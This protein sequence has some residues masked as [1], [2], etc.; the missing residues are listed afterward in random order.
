MS[1]FYLSKKQAKLGVVFCYTY[2][3]KNKIDNYREKFGDDC[4]EYIG[5]YL[6]HNILYDDN[7]N[8][9]VENHTPV[10]EQGRIDT[11]KY[12]I[13]DGVVKPYP[14]KDSFF[15]KPK[16][17]IENEIWIE[18][19]KDYEILEY[20]KQQIIHYTNELLKYQNAGFDN[21]TYRQCLDEY[22]KKHF[23]LSHAMALEV[24][25]ELR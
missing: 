17:D 7:L 1:Y 4:V 10:Y 20:Y 19:A 2:E 13:K 8:T 11:T 12:Y 3:M 9:I 14:E 25:N 18:T 24:Q 6:P 22:H 5:D 15:I 16:F 23:D 21:P